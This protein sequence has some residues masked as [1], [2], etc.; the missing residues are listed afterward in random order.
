MS[1]EWAGLKGSVRAIR[2][3]ERAMGILALIVLSCI[4]IV[5]FL[6]TLG[7]SLKSFLDVYKVP[8]IW[9]PRPP[10]WSNFADIFRVLPFHRFFINT[11]CITTL[12]LFGQVASASIVGYSFA[13]L[14]WPFRDF[15]FIVLLSTMM[16]PGQVTMI[17]IF[18]LFNKLGWV[19]TWLP[20]IVPAYF[21]GGVFNIFLLRQ[22]FK[23][24]P[25]ALEDAAKI[26]GCSQPRILLTI[27]LPLAKPALVTVTIL[28]FI[29]I[30]NDFMGPL[31]YLSDYVRYPISLGIY[32]FKSAQ[33][34]FPH[35]VMAASLVSLT[36][37]LILFFSAQRYFVKG[38]VLTGIKG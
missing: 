11:I 25:V 35:Y 3:I 9:I 18:L 12:S 7:D 32:M 31:I 34:M 21:G 30:W 33:G 1:R 24:I 27:M 15:F 22:F 14:R 37:V 38:I 36:P 6:I 16:L 17:P 13:R 2:R 8:R 28:G 29:G 5:P 23:T 26:D 4:F 19:N 20:L 10:Q